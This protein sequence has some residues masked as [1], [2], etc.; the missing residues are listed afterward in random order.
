MLVKVSEAVLVRN[1]CK[2]VI[3]L[4][5]CIYSGE[6][7]GRQVRTSPQQGDGGKNRASSLRV[8]PAFLKLD[9]KQRKYS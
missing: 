4:Y 7:C 5:Y 8:S 6:I 2:S 1:C 3:T 9:N